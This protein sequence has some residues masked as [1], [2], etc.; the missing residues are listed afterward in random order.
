MRQAVMD[1]YV[2][3]WQRWAEV[4]THFHGLAGLLPES[5]TVAEWCRMWVALVELAFQDDRAAETLQVLRKR[6]RALVRG[7]LRR[8]AGRG[9]SPDEMEHEPG[10][11]PK[12]ETELEPDDELGTAV[13]C[14][15]EGLRLRL[16]DSDPDLTFDDA[17][18]I[19]ERAVGA[20]DRDT[21]R[22]VA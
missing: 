19:L 21:G 18:L 8:A 5:P 17:R 16:S 9:R 3:R 14:L 15:V 2:A 4:R 13:H 10:H 22:H 7:V 11:E 20:S 12:N 1:R 6:E